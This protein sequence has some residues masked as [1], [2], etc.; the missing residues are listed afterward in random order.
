MFDINE[1][2]A[3]QAGRNHQQVNQKAAKIAA[4]VTLALIKSTASILQKLIQGIINRLRGKKDSSIEIK[5]NN[6]LVFKGKVG[7]KPTVNKLSLN[8]LTAILESAIA[9]SK[10][11]L[12]LLVKADNKI[13]Y[14]SNRGKVKLDQ[15]DD[16]LQVAKNPEQ[17]VVASQKKGENVVNKP[18]AANPPKIIVPTNEQQ[19]A[20]THA[21]SA[22]DYELESNSLLAV[23]SAK[24]V[25]DKLQTNSYED[26]NY[27]FRRD[28]SNITVHAKDGRG[29]IARLEAGRITSNNLSQNDVTS[30]IQIAD[31]LKLQPE[32][33]IQAVQQQANP[34]GQLPK[35]KTAVKQ[36]QKSEE[37]VEK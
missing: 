31:E 22:P 17:Q 13:V 28:G 33:A 16:F 21:K 30:L 1:H 37:E 9:D 14:A 6:Q 15:L 3:L 5:I 20:S 2:T 25:L 10:Q 27:S 19:N 24:Q 7:E 32:S 11:N 26:K 12:E 23:L 4:T 18:S 35:P 29:E 36:P 8:D 34:D